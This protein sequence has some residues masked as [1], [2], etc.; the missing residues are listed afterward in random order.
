MMEDVYSWAISSLG[1]SSSTLND[2]VSPVG[3]LVSVVASLLLNS[4]SNGPFAPPP[5]LPK[6]LDSKNSSLAPP[7]GNRSTHGSGPQDV[8][9][10]GVTRHYDFA[11]AR[12]V[13]ALDG[14]NKSSILINNQ[15]PGVSEHMSL[16]M[17]IIF[18]EF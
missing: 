12:G 5:N 14:V 2:Y 4:P 8:P 17:M 9:D 6:F 1:N 7:W 15:Y 11:V 16:P 10:T 18:T 3:V 13:I